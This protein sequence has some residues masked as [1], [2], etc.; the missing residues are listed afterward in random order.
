MINIK[1]RIFKLLDEA[2]RLRT[3]FN[4]G[5]QSVSVGIRIMKGEKENGVIV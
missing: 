3:P 5:V 4:M 1:Y 2:L